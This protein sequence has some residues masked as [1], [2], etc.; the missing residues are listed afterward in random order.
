MRSRG[1][2]L[3]NALLN[4][5]AA[6]GAAC[7]IA[8]LCALLFNITLIMFK[9]GSMAPAIPAGSLAVVRAI[10]ASDVS[11]GDV[12]TVDRPG[13]LPITHRVQTVQPGEGATRIITMKGDANAQ[14][15]PEPYVVD[16]VRV[17][18]WSAPGLAYPLAATATPLALG[19]TTAAVSALVTWVLW[20]RRVKDHGRRRAAGSHKK[21]GQE[22]K[23][24]AGAAL[25]LVPAFLIPLSGTTGQTE[26]SWQR[27][28][29]APAYLGA[30]TVPAPVL[31]GPCSYNPGVLGLGAYVRIR[32]LPPST[33]SLTDAEVQASTSGLGSAL[34][35]LTGFS[36][37]G[38]NTTGNAL[39][40]YVTDV[41]TNLLGGLLGLGTELQLA[42]VVK[43]Y[44]W[45]SQ[46][47][48]VASNAGLV[49]G[50]GGTCRN[51]T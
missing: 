29:P 10:P 13:K 27:S 28:N 39:T 9:T 46:A 50:L 16:Q 5:A 14:D 49:A 3:R 36:F 42:I 21:G 8:V 4:I 34:A 47:A 19:A 6:G 1:A 7:I 33:Y 40:G 15:D 12:V 25:L 18:L 44:T 37:S 30:L 48:S 32:W 38:S 22:K 17:V 11:V 45:T 20:P 51:L 35:P 26:A 31:N 2:K 23:A 24:T 41:P 43:R